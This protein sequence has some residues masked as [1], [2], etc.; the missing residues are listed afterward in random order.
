M[1]DRRAQERMESYCES[2]AE[3]ENYRHKY[4]EQQKMTVDEMIKAG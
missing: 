4:A 2:L 3:S 1:R